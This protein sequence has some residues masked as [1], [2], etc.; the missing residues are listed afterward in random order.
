MDV[1]FADGVY[2]YEPKQTPVLNDNGEI[3]GYESPLV[4]PCTLRESEDLR[5]KS[6]PNELGCSAD[7]DNVQGFAA[8]LD[9]INANRN[10]KT[11]GLSPVGQDDCGMMSEVSDAIKKSKSYEQK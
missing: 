4:T 9:I 3:I 5:V 8:T 10:T 2:F 7:P 6:A 11:S 1:N